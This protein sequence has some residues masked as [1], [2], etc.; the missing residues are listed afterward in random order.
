MRRGRAGGVARGGL[1]RL[2]GFR[3]RIRCK[4]SRFRTI[5]VV[6]FARILKSNLESLVR[7]VTFFRQSWYL[8]L[9]L[10]GDYNENIYIYFFSNLNVRFKQ[11]YPS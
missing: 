11:N 9:D 1:V 5:D 3:V 6:E 10:F 8:N 2:G 7:L 4:A